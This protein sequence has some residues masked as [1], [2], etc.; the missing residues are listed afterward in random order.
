M[1]HEPYAKRKC[2]NSHYSWSTVKGLTG[3]GGQV[4]GVSPFP[5]GLVQLNANWRVKACA[6]GPPKPP[7]P[8]CAIE[9]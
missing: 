6:E 5:L 3:V 1:F 7:P 4:P 2:Q 9:N 8:L